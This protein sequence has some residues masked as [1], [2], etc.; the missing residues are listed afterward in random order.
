MKHLFRPALTV[1]T[2]TALA[3]CGDDGQGTGAAP[4]IFTVPEITTETLPEARVGEQYSTTVEVRGGSGNDVQWSLMPGDML[5]SGIYFTT[6][7]LPLVLSGR[8]NTAG[9]FE[10]G[11]RYRDSTIANEVDSATVALSLTI[12][13]PPDDIVVTVDGL[14]P[15]GGGAWLLDD[16]IDAQFSATGGFGSGYTFSPVNSAALPPG[17]ELSLDGRLT[18][19]LT[20]VGT[21]NFILQVADPRGITV[22][23]TFGLTVIEIIDNPVWVNPNDPNAEVECPDG[24]VN[25]AYECQLCMMG[26]EPPYGFEISVEGGVPPGLQLQQ[27]NEMNTCG[28]LRGTPSEAGAYAFAIFGQDTQAPR[29]RQR[30]FVD[31]E[32]A[33]QPLRISGRVIRRNP[34]PVVDSFVFPV[35]ER[36]TFYEYD[37]AASGGDAEGRSWQV[38]PDS[39]GLPDGMTLSD[40]D[41]SNDFFGRLTGAPS[42]LA[43][44]Q[45]DLCVGNAPGR[46]DDRRDFEII[47]GPASRDLEFQTLNLPAATCGV[48][49]S[50]TVTV[51]GGR[52]DGEY[53]WAVMPADGL[54]AGLTVTPVAR[55]STQISGTPTA[56]GSFDFD[57]E[58]YDEDN[59]MAVRDFTLL[60]NGPCP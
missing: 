4:I 58:V 20:S 34:L 43:V 8:P 59:R 21:F 57:L 55:P 46:I 13:A 28:V 60:V 35:L 30:F 12:A 51:D 37:I 41:A 38:C 36:N 56:S 44:F 5:P 9:T 49:Y 25:E 19:Q 27:P 42:R 53:G 23:Q 54:P 45:F 16:T 47:V 29:V 26:G 39:D 2:I 1:W 32:V 24:R 48:P 14:T 3:A 31:I 15:D 50:A 52:F 10:F 22:R 6:Q 11:L 18:G 7:S 40:G 17:T 33:L